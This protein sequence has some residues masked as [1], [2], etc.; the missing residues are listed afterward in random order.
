MKPM[1]KAPGTKRLTLKCDE[2]LSSFAFKFILRRYNEVV[3][4]KFSKRPPQYDHKLNAMVRL[5]A[6]FV[7]VTSMLFY[8]AKGVYNCLLTIIPS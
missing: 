6:S 2:P 3:L 8:K 4:L 5:Y 1:L 7:C